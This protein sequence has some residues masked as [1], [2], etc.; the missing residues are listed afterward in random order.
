[1]LLASER[2]PHED[3]ALIVIDQDGETVAAAHE[4]PVAVDLR[5]GEAGGRDVVGRV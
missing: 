1:M 4:D 5:R 2:I 3:L